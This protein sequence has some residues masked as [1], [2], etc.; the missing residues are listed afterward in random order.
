L[1]TDGGLGKSETWEMKENR[2][3][4]C[5]G[6]DQWLTALTLAIVDS[7]KNITFNSQHSMLQ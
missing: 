1:N 4:S 3:R 7:Q 2:A 5:S 6:A